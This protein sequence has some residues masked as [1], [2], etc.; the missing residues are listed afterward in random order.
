MGLT[1][2]GNQSLAFGDGAKS[3]VIR[4]LMLTFF[5]ACSIYGCPPKTAVKM[6]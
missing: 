6:T 5:L 4:G 1:G 3:S 2:R